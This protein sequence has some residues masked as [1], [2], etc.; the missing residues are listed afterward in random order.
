MKNTVTD[1]SPLTA[2]KILQ[3][4]IV[5]TSLLFISG[6]GEVDEGDGTVV[7]S[8][9]LPT[10][11]SLTLYCPD[12]GIAANPCVLDDPENPYAITPI[13]DANKFDLSAAAPS[14]KA[15]FYLWATAQAI[16]PRGENQFYVA[17]ALQE[18]YGESGSELAREQALRAYR[19]VLDNYFYSVTFF[20]ATWVGGD[21][22][23]YPFPVRKL[24]GQNMYNPATLTPLFDVPAEALQMF[25]MW[26]YTYDD[27]VTLDFTPNY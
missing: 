23:Y 19:S 14:A 6:C 3:L 2:A 1:H 12:A 9:N 16:S 20:E 4:L 22:I 11:S 27:A 18:M 13:S 26:G 8:I 5:S 24:V 7:N 10:D 21:D 25:G 17:G 15:R